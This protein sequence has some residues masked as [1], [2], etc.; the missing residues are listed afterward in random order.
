MGVSM[1]K[2]LSIDIISKILNNIQPNSQLIDYRIEKITTGIA[3]T[4]HIYKMHLK[5]EYSLNNQE[6]YLIV[7]VANEELKEIF[8]FLDFYE[9]EIFVYENILPKQNILAYPNCYFSHYDKSKGDFILVMQDLAYKYKITQLEGC[10][11]VV[12][13]KVLKQLALFHNYWHDHYIIYSQNLAGWNR[14]Q[15]IF[16]QEDFENCWK[17]CWNIFAEYMP[18]EFMEQHEKMKR[19]YMKIWEGINTEPKSIIHFDLRLDNLIFSEESHLKAIIDWQL[20]RVGNIAYDVSL[21]IVGNLNVTD[22]SQYQKLLQYYYCHLTINYSYEDFIHDFRKSL[23]CHFYREINYL[24]SDD[25]DYEQKE[26]YAKKVF[27]RYKRA[28][29][30]FRVVEL[31]D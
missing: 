25:Y 16:N 28:L 7:K 8:N 13:M 27:I 1:N 23:L 10:N 17:N 11:E 18:V 24:G 19:K 15:L 5:Y 14:E 26:Q 29:Q 20:A 30:F 3:L 4:S 22:N 9:K 12:L 21:L 2:F 31:L 6:T